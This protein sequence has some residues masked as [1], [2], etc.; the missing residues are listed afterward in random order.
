MALHQHDHAV[1]GCSPK[2]NLFS[3]AQS[4][5]K[6]SHRKDRQRW[7]TTRP[8][9]QESCCRCCRQPNGRHTLVPS[10]S[11]GC[12]PSPAS[13]PKPGCW[14]AVPAMPRWP[15]CWPLATACRRGWSLA[16]LTCAGSRMVWPIR[17]V[18]SPG[19]IRRRLATAAGWRCVE[20]ARGTLLHQIELD[21]DRLGATPSSRRPNGTFTRKGRLSA[22]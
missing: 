22:R 12:R 14:H 8:W 9:L 3:Q 5:E 20:T 13:R 1:F 2:E 17:N 21:G 18:C 10:P 19:L 6:P 11:P 7:T 16:T 15:D 4:W